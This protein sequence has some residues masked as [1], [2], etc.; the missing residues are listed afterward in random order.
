MRL[1]L[2]LPQSELASMVGASR[3][4]VNK[5]LQRLQRDGL[6]VIDYNVIQV[7]DAEG[8]RRLLETQ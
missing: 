6:I 1:A 2:R 8:L 3:Q 5:S 7:R 4:S